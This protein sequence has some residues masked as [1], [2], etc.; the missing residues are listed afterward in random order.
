MSEQLQVGQYILQRKLGEGGMAQVWEAHHIHL[1]TTV[2]IKFLLPALA[3]DRDLEDRFLHESKRLARLVHPNIVPA[4]DFIQQDGRSY[5]VMQYIDGENL[6]TKLKDRNGP[7]DLDEIHNISWDVLSAL[8]CAHTVGFVHRDVKPSNIIVDTSGR[9]WLMDFGIALAMEE[10]RRLT[11]TGTAVGTPDYMSPEQIV[12][13]KDVDPRSDIYSFGCVL[14]AMLSGAPPFGGEGSS[15]YHIKESHVRT[16]PPPLRDRNASISPAIEEVVHHCLQKEPED[17]PQTCAEVLRSFE[18]AISEQ[19]GIRAS[20]KPVSAPS[21]PTLSAFAVSESLSIEKPAAP[22]PLAPVELRP[23]RGGGKT[24][25]RLEATTRRS[26][27]PL[28]SLLGLLL[29]AALVAGYFFLFSSPE[30]VL[31]LEG[32]TTIGDELA[33]ALL[34]AFLASEGATDIKEVH[35]TGSGKDHHDVQA[36]LSGSWRPVVFSVVANGSSKA[37]AA[38]HAGTADIGM[39]SSPI[40]DKDF[41]LLRP[42]GDM[43]SPACENVVALDGIAIIVNPA[44]PLPS[45]TRGQLAAVFSGTI[46]DWSQ[47]GIRPGP[48]QLF[49]R[50]SGSGTYKTFADLVM[51]GKGFAST[52]QVKDNGEEITRNVLADPNAI[53]YVALAQ[54]G[55]ATP[56]PLSSA[57]DTIPLI[58][59]PFTV[60]TEDYILSRRLLLYTPA[61]PT[62][63]AR[64]FVN[65]SLSAPGQEVVKKVN[66]VQQTP[67]FEVVSIPAGAPAEYRAIVTGMRRMSLNFRFRSNGTDLDNKALADIQRAATSLNQNGIREGVQILGFADSRGGANPRLSRERAEVVASRFRSYDISVNVAGFSSAMPVGD[68]NLEE[69]RQ[70]NRR[71]EVWVR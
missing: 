16:P 41:N 57:P 22:A 27:V 68:N 35:D 29:V 23:A 12:R 34:K 7:L 46:T 42:L 26:R 5:L 20:V 6:E 37:F 44:N 40:G 30:T 11:R 65:F 47:L 71:V 52:L 32:S 63:L 64:K 9:A 54:T 13:P 21:V 55:G 33:P 19:D 49:G 59:S 69:G 10:E 14:Y 15:E 2:A 43:R 58:P 50:D 18:Q 25:P 66:F 60:A 3:N 51:G 4:I 38:L 48:I 62:E 67:H 24:G 8:D 17:R 28:Y 39:A 70:K 31:R 61:N 45:L 36:K 53:G 56:L 1:N